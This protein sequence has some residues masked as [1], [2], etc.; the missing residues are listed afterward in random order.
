MERKGKIEYSLLS[1]SDK[2]DKA[3][4]SR[5]QVADK[6]GVNRKTVYMWLTGQSTMPT[7]AAVEI[8]DMLGCTLDELFGREPVAPVGNDLIAVIYDSLNDDG[9]RNMEEHAIMC[10][11]NPRFEKR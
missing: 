7:Y 11:L 9:K 1:I 8:S 4:I 2:L 6:L 10:R 3:G 5:A